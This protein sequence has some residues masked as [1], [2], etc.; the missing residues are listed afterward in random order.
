MGCPPFRPRL[1]LEPWL[2]PRTQSPVLR[3]SISMGLPIQPLDR[4]WEGLH[5]P[6]VCLLCLRISN[7]LIPHLHL[8]RPFLAP[9]V[10]L[11][12]ANSMVWNVFLG[13][14]MAWEYGFSL[15][16]FGGWEEWRIVWER[17]GNGVTKSCGSR[18]KNMTMKALK[19]NELVVVIPPSDLNLIIRTPT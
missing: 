13:F 4:P 3:R 7:G 9:G 10:D 19:W 5:R 8:P 15:D 2:Q 16:C 18:T 17:W 11:T 6:L 14:I 1:A 12:K